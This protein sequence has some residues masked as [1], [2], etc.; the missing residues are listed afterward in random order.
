[1]KISFLCPSISRTAGGIFE[2]ERNL[3]LTLMR[4]TGAQVE[5]FSPS[6][7]HTESDL[8]AWVPLKP[9]HFPF[10]GPDSFRY[11]PGLR[12]AFLNQE[13]D[14][15]HL[16]ALWMYNSI[17]I[18]QWSRRWQ[19]PYIITANGMLEAWAVKN[20]VWKKRLALA[21]YERR[22]LD[23]AA[24]IQVNSQAEYRSVR[25]FGLRN[26]IA[27]IPNGIDLPEAG[28]PAAGGPGTAGGGQK[29]QVAGLKT[30]GRKVLLYLGRIHP[31]KGLV[32]LLRAWAKTGKNQP[33]V[34]GIAGWDQGGHEA[35]LKLL[36]TELGLVWQDVRSPLTEAS[37]PP[38]VVFLGPQFDDAKADCYRNCDGFILPSFS[39]G[40]PM[41]VLEAWAYGKAV[42]MTPECNLPAGFERGAA[43]R[44]EANAESIG[45]GLEDFFGAPEAGR[46]LLGENGLGL[47]R[48][49]FVWPVL[50]REMKRVYEWMLGGG[51]K[52]NCVE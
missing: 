29:S 5:I 25:A 18:R 27:L 30:E 19:R 6:D 31:K 38:T 8:P 51:P 50:A 46:Q 23:G 2:I 48:E 11:S 39:E 7:L 33:W 14:L 40:L 42:L 34:L 20:S 22:C 13:S 45:S 49:Q 9:R 17:L 15:S 16:H 24:C 43:L 37:A 12:R 41:V 10:F 52:P 1:M 26:P 36:A 3:A 47:V 28:A 21:F 35:Q 44:I 4:E 32:N